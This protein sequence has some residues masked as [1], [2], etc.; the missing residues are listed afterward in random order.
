MTRRNHG[1]ITPPRWRPPIWLWHAILAVF[2]AGYAVAAALHADWRAAA[3]GLGCA[4]VC[5]WAAIEQAQK[6]IDR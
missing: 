4:I 2:A 6:E 1:K 5:G 3:F